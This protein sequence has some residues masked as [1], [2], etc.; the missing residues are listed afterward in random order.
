MATYAAC[1][2]VMSRALGQDTVLLDTVSGTYFR[3]NETGSLV[4]ARLASASSA[5][6]LADELV[7]ASEADVDIARRDVAE[8][9][10]A[11]QSRGLITVGP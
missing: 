1:P 3:L 5:D 11:L 8:L 9:L 10:E 2:G 7:K 6:E 4:W